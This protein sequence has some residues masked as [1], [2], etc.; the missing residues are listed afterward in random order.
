M[1]LFCGK[2]RGAISV[3]LTLIL[4]P[5][6]VFSG[7]I[8]DA[9]RLFASKIV[10]S[11]AGDLTMNAALSRYDKNLKDDYGLM[12][13][14]DSPDSPKIL[15]D[16]EQYFLESCNASYVEGENLT[17]LHSMIQLEL[18][19]TGLKAQGVESSSL[20]NTDVLQQQMLEYMKFRAPVYVVNDI[21]EKFRNL[22]MNNMN[23]KKD[24]ID[25]KTEYGKA[26]SK[27]GEPLQKA[28][29][30]ADKHME[31]INWIDPDA[32]YSAVK[33]YRDNKSI[34]WL[35]ARSLD[36]YMSGYCVA[37]RGGGTIDA[38]RIRENMAGMVIWDKNN[39]IFDDYVYV[40]II[41]AVSIYQI[42]S[43]QPEIAA[44]ITVENGF[45]REEVDQ[46]ER[47]GSDISN[48]I[49]NM[50]A[51][52]RNAESNYKNEIAAYEN[53]AKEIRD[54]GNDAVKALKKVISVYENK[55]LKAKNEYDTAKNELEKAGESTE[56]LEDE[57]EQMEINVEDVKALIAAIE[58]NVSSAETF[59]GQLDSLKE[60]PDR[61]SNTHL[62]QDEGLL[63]VDYGSSGAIDQYWESHRDEINVPDSISLGSNNI[64]E[65]KF[66]RETLSQVT[67][68][69]EEDLEKK[70]QKEKSI[71]DASNSQNKYGELINLIKNGIYEIDL[72]KDITDMAY[73]DD[74]PSGMANAASGLASGYEVKKIDIS[75]DAAVIDGSKDT[76]SQLDELIVGLDKLAGTV[77]ERVY[78]MEYMAEMFNCLTTKED[79]ESLSGQKLSSHI[80]YNGEI[81]YILF[82][83]SS[84][85]LNKAAAVGQIFAIRLA[86][87]SIYI[88]FDKE[89][90]AEANSIASALST[91]IGLPWLYPV[92]KYGYLFCRAIIISCQDVAQLAT[93]KDVLVWHGDT[94]KGIKLNYK[95]YLKLLLIVSLFNEQQKCTFLARTGDC[96][97]LNI[98]AELSEK[99]TMLTLQADVKSTTTFLPKVPAF[100]GNPEEENDGKKTIRYKGVLAY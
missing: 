59:L 28:K 25:K 30:A 56:G 81:E 66:Y 99:Y 33:D 79:A 53:T 94:D 58:A 34:F 4:V 87:N 70:S 97:Q 62:K 37:W 61:L 75:A 52:H 49:S 48:N 50:D 38:D 78:L 32:I 6:L 89:M 47:L 100:L 51:V 98:G 72:K 3:F 16:L 17:D 60:I 39:A 65:D 73:P 35:A 27:L 92:I 13:M 10:I 83:N 12:A 71:T 54:S 57:D 91:S 36:D 96:I 43:E 18:G 77:L 40:D 14:A 93:G 29:V 86:I 82:G 20:A 24:Y 8:V 41:A 9:S 85:A 11:G 15:E 42:C 26:L 90:N 64:Y 68:K 7:I 5:V 1:R 22:P 44:E 74:F 95:E 80:I 69:Q 55:V 88:F 2:N 23:E 63:I 31:A 76:F 46:Y 21:I 67:E 45:T 19:A 84:T